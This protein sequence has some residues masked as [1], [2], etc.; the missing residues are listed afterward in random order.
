MDIIFILQDEGYCCCGE[1]QGREIIACFC[2]KHGATVINDGGE[3]EYAMNDTQQVAHYLAT[4][5]TCIK[6]AGDGKLCKVH[7]N[8]PQMI[9]ALSGR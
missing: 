3:L 9:R 7:S 5:C 4:G 2:P 1:D 8:A 6:K